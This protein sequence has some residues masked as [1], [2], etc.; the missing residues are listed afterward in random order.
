[1]HNI[2][3]LK[4]KKQGR[5]KQGYIDPKSCKKL[6]KGCDNIIIYRSSY[7]FKFITWLENNNKVKEWGSECICIPYLFADGKMHR[8]YPDYYVEMVD[9]T[10]MVVEIKPYNQTKKPIN[11][12]CWAAK[13]YAK[14]MCKW[15]AAKEFCDA[16][17]YRFQILTERTINQI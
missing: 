1:M 5:Y 2:K 15:K 17:G 8:Y 4:P 14:N 13:E 11:E 6:I 3:Q 12:N 10:K 7:E 16:K 9:G